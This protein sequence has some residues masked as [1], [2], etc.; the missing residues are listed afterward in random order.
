MSPDFTN[1]ARHVIGIGD[2]AVRQARNGVIITHA[3]GS[4]LGIILYDSVAGI[5]GMLHAQLPLAARSPQRAQEK[6]GIFV[7]LGIPLLLDA[8]TRLGADRRRMRI[9]VVGGANVIKTENDMFNIA[10]HNLTMMRKILWQ[11]DLRLAGEDTGGTRPRTVSLDLATGS[12]VIE[13][14]GQCTIL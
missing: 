3:L 4:C 14:G 13:S 1:G 12:T 5:G 7:D 2:L 6:P 9:T 10:K 8:A 11:L